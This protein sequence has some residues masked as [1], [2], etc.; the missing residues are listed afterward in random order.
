MA[1]FVLQQLQAGPAPPPDW[2]QPGE[3]VTGVIN[4]SPVDE[5]HL[6]H[7]VVHL[8]PGEG[9]RD[10]VLAP[11]GHLRVLV[12]PVSEAADYSSWGWGTFIIGGILT[13][14][15]MYNAYLSRHQ[16]SWLRLS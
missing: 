10:E 4:I 3:V 11:E 1:S 7:D 9:L 14:C 13:A 8:Q 15:I 12:A 2:A 5:V 6:P 16:I